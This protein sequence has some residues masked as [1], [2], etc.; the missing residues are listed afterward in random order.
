[1]NEVKRDNE[2][3]RQIT[4]FQLSIENLVRGGPGRLGVRPRGRGA[5][6]LLSCPLARP[7]ACCVGPVSGPLRPAK[8][9]RGAQDHLGGAALQDGQVGGAN[10]DLGRRVDRCG[11]SLLIS[12]LGSQYG[13]GQEKGQISRWTSGWRVDG[14]AGICG[15]S[16]HHGGRGA[17]R[18]GIAWIFWVGSK[19]A[20][21]YSQAG[22]R[23]GKES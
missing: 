15:R 20:A 22:D 10:T 1:M 12:R 11:V 5:A 7:P 19:C 13:S 8:D 23:E 3:L 9:R 16:Q 6:L 14:Q 4:N 2:T 21:G 18:A 17:G